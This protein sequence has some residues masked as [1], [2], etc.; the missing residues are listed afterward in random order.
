MLDC[1]R[2]FENEFGRRLT[3][4]CGRSLPLKMSFGS[5][6]PGLQ[7]LSTGTTGLAGTSSIVRF[8]NDWRAAGFS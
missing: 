6:S 7:L 4:G 8:L 1:L 2:P 3:D 5:F